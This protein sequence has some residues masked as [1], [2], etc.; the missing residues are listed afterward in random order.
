MIV[1]SREAMPQ[2]LGAVREGVPVS[3]DIAQTIASWYHSGSRV[4]EP[5]TALSHGLPFDSAELVSRLDALLGSA[6]F[7]GTV[8]VVELHALRDWVL[9][10]EPHLVITEYRMSGD[11]W[12]A[13]QSSP[14]DDP[15][16][17]R[18]E[19]IEPRGVEVV[20]ISAGQEALAEWV[21]PE[22]ARYPADADSYA[23]GD[24]AEGGGVWMRASLVDG[25]AVM[26]AGKCTDF[27]AQTYGADPF[28]WNPYWWQA[29]ADAFGE[30]VRRE[31]ASR[32]EDMR[33][34]EV[35]ITTARLVGLTDE[36]E[37]AVWQRW[38]EPR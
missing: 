32:E 8:A 17:D 31:Y 22:E 2:I 33:D 26:L 15:D 27:W 13:W 16:R 4:D 7:A 11:E 36:Q 12:D 14:V 6:E 30:A 24:R 19:G 10:R 1:T 28:D 35:T 37:R 25:A 38:S 23:E 34:G 5:L 21:Y 20:L 3:D 18:P 9:A 29:S